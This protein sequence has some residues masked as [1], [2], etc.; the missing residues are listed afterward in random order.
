MTRQNKDSSFIKISDQKAFTFIELIIVIAVLGILA[1]VAVSFFRFYIPKAHN[2]TVKHALQD[3]AKA[4]ETYYTDN[5]RYLGIT[6]DY[7][8]GGTPP[9]GPLYQPTLYYF[10]SKGIRIEIISGDGNNPF[11]APVFKA[12]GSHPSASMNYIFD[13]STAQITERPK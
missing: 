13:F 10:P 4:Q 6:G 1:S 8:V 7:I 12:E 9:N 11:D 2:I 3:F 5:G